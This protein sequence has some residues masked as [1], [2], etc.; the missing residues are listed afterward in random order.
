MDIKIKIFLLRIIGKT[1]EWYTCTCKLILKKFFKHSFL[2]NYRNWV[3]CIEPFRKYWMDTFSSMQDIHVAAWWSITWWCSLSGGRCGVTHTAVW[4]TNHRHYIERPLSPPQPYP[5]RGAGARS[6]ESRP[7]LPLFLVP[8]NC[9]CCK[10][11]SFDKFK[12]LSDL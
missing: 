4:R 10:Q 6:S 8:V 1:I 7:P 3:Y 12:R 5:P 9:S 2:L 11:N